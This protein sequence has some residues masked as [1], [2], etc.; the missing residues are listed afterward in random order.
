[1]PS[2]CGIV[3][4][5]A[6]GNGGLP[7][8]NTKTG[9]GDSYNNAVIPT[10]SDQLGNAPVAYVPVTFADGL[11]SNIVYGGAGGAFTATGA[12]QPGQAGPPS[13][14]MLYFSL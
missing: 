9:P 8:N 6:G 13:M 3:R 5:G 7:T 14:F 12:P 10:G 11:I 4:G 2:Y 1:M